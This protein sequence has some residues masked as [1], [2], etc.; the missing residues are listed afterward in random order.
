MLSGRLHHFLAARSAVTGPN[1]VIQ[2]ALQWN[3]DMRPK[4][5][6][7]FAMADQPCAK[8]TFMVVIR[9]AAGTPW[10]Q[11]IRPWPALSIAAASKMYIAFRS[12][13]AS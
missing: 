9:A 1:Q 8:P 5:L 12:S 3:I 4:F 11:P 10:A 13:I 6:V 7:T 2:V